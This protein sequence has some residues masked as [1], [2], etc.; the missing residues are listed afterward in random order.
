MKDLSILICSLT[1]RSKYLERL[2]AA[3]QPQLNERVEVLIEIDDGKISIGDKRN[4]LLSK[5][6]GKYIS[7][8]DD[9]DLVESIYVDKILEATGQ[10]PD[11]VGIHLLHFENDILRGLTYHS[12]KYTHWWNERNKENPDLINYYRNP[13]HINPVK[14]D[15]ASQIKF[16][17][18]NREEDHDYSTRLLP[19]LKTEVYI[20]DPIYRYLVRSPKE[21]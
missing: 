5:A 10:N 16:P 21:C 19:L 4:I 1:S 6:S 12:L 7:F 14:K 20:E 2:N 3:I 15:L 11:V 13:N 17:S 18:V 9:D 8:V